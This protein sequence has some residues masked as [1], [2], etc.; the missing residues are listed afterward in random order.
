MQEIDQLQ[1]DELEI[2]LEMFKAAKQSNF[3]LFDEG[4]ARV[5]SGK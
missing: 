3:T 4:A 5:H 2:M 1:T